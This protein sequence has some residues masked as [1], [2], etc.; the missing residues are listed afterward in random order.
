MTEDRR[1]IDTK[2]SNDIRVVTEEIP[3]AKSVALG[4]WTNVGSRDEK[5][6]FSGYSHFLEHLLFKG[7]TKKTSK[8]IS[9]IIEAKG[10]YLNA[11]TDR[12]MTCF[13][14]RVLK[15]DMESAIDVLSDVVQNPLLRQEDIKKE[16][17]V[18]RSE[19]SRRDD[20]PEDLIHDLCVEKAW[21]GND[22]AHSVLGDY[23]H[24]TKLSQ[25]SV[26][27][28]Y[29]EH[30]IPANMILTATGALSHDEVVDLAEKYL[31]FQRQGELR[32]RVK[33]SLK[34]GINFIERKSS[35][36]QISISSEG[37]A[38]G[39]DLK[40]PLTL[41]HSYLGLGSS[42]KLFQEVREK[43]GL[44]YS[45]Y[46]N[47]YSLSDA[48]LFTIYAGAKEENTEK[49]IQTTLDELE[50]LRNGDESMNLDEIK[51]KT[52]GLTI[53]RSESPE[54]RMIQLGITTLRIGKPRTINEIIE[55]I[56][57]V[58]LAT[59]MKTSKNIFARERLSLT[60]LGLSKEI[61]PRVEALLD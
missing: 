13:H 33:P 18:I 14:A 56:E 19:I 17:Q 44:V 7:T 28:Y 36:V 39:D 38:Q 57:G 58:S 29:K 41:L 50:A 51:H 21:R 40:A 15:K 12:D 8:E 4:L 55:E 30:Y 49:V 26:R 52:T 60:I 47:N 37:A 3:G 11:F 1:V 16:L 22:A 61:V 43:Q 35:Q 48:G 27:K 5:K 46:T 59:I 54:S 45:I 20:D 34:P 42:S 53:L 25:D 24:L 9:T 6:E 32:T 2:L 23:D 10:G 31:N